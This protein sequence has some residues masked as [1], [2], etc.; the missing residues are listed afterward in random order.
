VWTIPF[1]LPLLHLKSVNKLITIS[2]LAHTGMILPT[3]GKELICQTHTLIKY[4]IHCSQIKPVYAQTFTSIASALLCCQMKKCVVNVVLLHKEDAQC[5]SLTGFKTQL[6]REK[7]TK[8]GMFMI[9][10]C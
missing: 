3:A 10:G 9:I 6:S 7:F 2:P 8:D 1:G 5:F 4:A